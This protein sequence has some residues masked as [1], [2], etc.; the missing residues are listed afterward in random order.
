MS[1]FDYSSKYLW[2]PGPDAV[3]DGPCTFGPVFFVPLMKE[4]PQ[5]LWASIQEVGSA[6]WKVGGERRG[7][8]HRATCSSVRVDGLLCTQ[9]SLGSEAVMMTTVYLHDV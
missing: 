9:S 5:D 6:C 1:L 4:S 7:S 2:K 3:R 8:G